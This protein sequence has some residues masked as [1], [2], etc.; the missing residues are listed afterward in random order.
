MVASA[1]TFEDLVDPEILEAMASL[2]TL[3]L[4]ADLG[5]QRI[6]VATNCMAT[7]TH[8]KCE[9]KGPSAVTIQDIK[10]RMQDFTSVDF[11]HEKREM[12]VEAHKLSKAAITLPFGR[13]IWLSILHDII[14]I[15]ELIF[16]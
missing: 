4:A 5:C 9:Y 3:F 11:I 8:L 7:I 1:I 14:C 15:L 12:N 10:Q 6:V 16:I 13:H 2:E